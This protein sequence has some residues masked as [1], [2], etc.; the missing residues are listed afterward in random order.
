MGYV[1]PHDRR[2]P[3][4]RPLAA[5]QALEPTFGTRALLGWPG[6]LMAA[7]AREHVAPPERLLTGEG[8]REREIGA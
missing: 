5:A 3:R 1:A 7:L 4:R 2:Y 6:A 8:G